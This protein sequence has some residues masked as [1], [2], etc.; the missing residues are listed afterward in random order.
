[1]A[2]TTPCFVRKLVDHASRRPCRPQRLRLPHK[3]GR[4]RRRLS[5]RLRN[6][7]GRH[8]TWCVV[9]VGAG[10]P[11]GRP[12]SRVELTRPGSPA[13]TAEVNAVDHPLRTPG[14]PHPPVAPRRCSVRRSIRRGLHGVHVALGASGT[15]LHALGV[16]LLNTRTSRTT[17]P[18]V[19]PRAGVRACACSHTSTH[20]RLGNTCSCV[21]RYSNALLHWMM[22]Q[23]QH[24][25]G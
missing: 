8:M 16:F 18:R 1:M 2:C 10:T 25:R 3:A 7:H 22:P 11:A 19:L 21:L 5:S 9:Q 17:C 4:A 20:V 23:G 15:R 24:T 12:S 14:P 13:C 6:Q